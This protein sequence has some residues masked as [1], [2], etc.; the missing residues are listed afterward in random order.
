MLHAALDF[1]PKSPTAAVVLLHGF[2]AD[3]ADLVALAPALRT[4][5]PDAIAQHLLVAAPNAPDPTPMGMGYQWFSDAG[6][7]F[8]DKPGQD[9]T[10]TLLE[11]YIEKEIVQNKGVPWRRVVL[12]GFSQGT[13]QALYTAPRLTE[14]I[15]GVVGFSGALTWADEIIQAH[16]RMPILLV[17]GENDDVLPA[18]ATTHAAGELQNLGFRVSAK[19]L[20]HLGHSIESRG[21]KL[22][23]EFIEN[24]LK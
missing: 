14:K 17:H 8:M 19:V 10:L 1:P 20:P 2:G 21:L 4:L 22:A 15:A 11:A 5:L 16:H 24:V 13:M 12:V 9:R 3:G 23:A 18:I 6:Y 7:T